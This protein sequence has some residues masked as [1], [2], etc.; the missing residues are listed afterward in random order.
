MRLALSILAA[1]SLAGCSDGGPSGP[2]SVAIVGNADGL[3][4]GGLRLPV[5]AQ[6]LRAASNEGLVGL[7]PAGEV[8]PALA[9][10]WI[11]TDEGKSYI[12]RLRDVQW[13]DG[14]SVTAQDV[15]TLLLDTQ[16]RLDNTSLG[17]DLAKIEDVRAMTGRVIEIRLTAAMPEFLRLL[18]QA[19]LGFVKDGT[20][21]GPMIVSRDDG[22]EAALLSA[23]PP[24]ARGFAAREDWEELARQ[25]MV[26]AMPG[27]EAITAFDEGEV[28]LV[29]NARLADLPL[30]DTGPLTRG[31]V[32]I[33]AAWGQFGLVFR[34][35]SG[36][37]AEAEQREALSMAIDRSALLQPFNI[38]G[39]IPALEVVPRELWGDVEPERLA[40]ADWSIERR[41]SVA[42][43]RITQW[44]NDSGQNASVTVSMPVGPGSDQLFAQIARDFASIGVAAS[45]AVD[46]QPADLL[47]HDRV[48]R[49]ASPRW[50]LNQFNCNVRSGPCSPEAD[51]LVA[52]S[53]LV[54][55]LQEKASLLAE[56][57]LE[58]TD[59]HVFIPFGAPIR[60][61]LVRSNVSGYAENQWGIHPLFPLSQ[62]TI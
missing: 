59:A 58:L 7:D 43:S 41:R 55:N 5:S 37:F 44:Q 56:A 19:E 26:Q 50:F 13:P 12:F 42:A 36:L 20:G 61:S 40:W 34:R 45:I 60:W 17:L 51:D 33:D 57:E 29:L 11:I 48:A 39:W 22:S 1:L 54:N 18:A 24:E 31:T 38:G 28:D 15:R 49:Y 3:F 52:Q 23:L 32:R 10:R 21:T 16:R 27:P 62:P 8:I 47:L 14:S 46:G 30:A 2:V 9:E 53:L 6:H 25:V 4:Q 35:E